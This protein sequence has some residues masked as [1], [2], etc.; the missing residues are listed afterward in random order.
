MRALPRL[1]VVVAVGC[2]TTTGG[3]VE[4]DAPV[5]PDSPIVAEDPG[6]EWFT[7]RL[8]TTPTVPFGG[9]PY[10]NYSVRLSDVRIDVT[11]HPTDGLSSI[12]VADTMNEATVGT[13]SFPPAPI[14][15][16]G[17]SYLGVPQPPDTN[18][19]FT[20]MLQELPTNSPKTA[21]GVSMTRPT[22]DALTSTVRWDRTDQAAPLAWTVTATNPIALDRRACEV[23]KIYCLGGSRQGLLYSCVDGSHLTRIKICT[24]GC[25]PADPPRT[26]HVDEQC[27]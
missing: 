17:F 7:G 2:T 21:I 15:R 6:V 3:V 23:G 25:V 11:M 13:C 8:A 5:A 26:P 20:P 16:Q 19:A 24:P 27:N 4:P 14:N 1:L 12:I 9:A 10:C 18:G 22:P